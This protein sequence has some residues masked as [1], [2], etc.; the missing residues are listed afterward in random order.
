MIVGAATVAI[1]SAV[2]VVSAPVPLLCIVVVDGIVVDVVGI[3]VVVV[4]PAVRKA[5]LPG[6]EMGRR[7]RVVEICRAAFA[8]IVVVGGIVVGLLF[9]PIL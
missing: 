9:L 8:A 1:S 2:V 3:S 5:R 7:G 4:S 6:V